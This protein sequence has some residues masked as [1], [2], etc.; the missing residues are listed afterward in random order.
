MLRTRGCSLPAR[1][2]G[3]ES[4]LLLVLERE[5][6]L[7]AVGDRPALVQVDVLLN[8]FSHPEIPDRPGGSLDRLRRRIFPGCAACSDDLG[9]SVYAHDLLPPG[10]GPQPA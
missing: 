6:Q 9:H 4:A 1:G 8:D 5:L 2:A 10:G 3:P 7:C